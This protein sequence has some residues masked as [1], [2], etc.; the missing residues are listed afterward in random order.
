MRILFVTNNYTP[1]SGGVIQSITATTQ[2]LRAQGHDVH[3]V[4]LNFLNTKQDDPEYVIRIACPIKFMYKKNHMA[5]PW[6]PTHAIENV[7]QDYKPDIIHVHHPFLLGASALNA[8]RKYA[9]PCIFTYHTI[10]EYHAHYIPLPRQVC[11]PIIRAI[12]HQFCKQVDA[13][14][15]PSSSVKNYLL[16][17]DIQTPIAII[18][19]PIRPCFALSPLEHKKND[20]LFS[21][22]LV[23]RFVPEKNIPFIFDVMQLLPNEFTITLVGYGV[24]YEKMKTLAYNTFNF[25]PERVRFIHQPN[26]QELL[27]TY[28][29]AD[30][31]IFPSTVDTQGIVL[32]ES[33]SQGVPVIALDGLGQRDIIKNG[34][35]GFI[36]KDAA[37]AAEKISTVARTPE[38]FGQLVIGAR[39]TAQKY[40]ANHIAQELTYL[41]TEYIKD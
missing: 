13:I 18:P 4:T 26:Q 23:S 30:L 27:N 12:A 15:A 34:I 33:M 19:S 39:T 9:I 38:L 32:A 6:R 22:L 11:Q 3:I 24:D 37:D 16:S 28:Q 29:T 5:I 1:Y 36:I 31:F 35:N 21:L 20:K 14:I 2:A 17:Q 8:A 41:Y 10:Y 7:I 40:H 25:S